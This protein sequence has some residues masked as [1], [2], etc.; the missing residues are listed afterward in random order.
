MDVSGSA[1]TLTS[2]DAEPLGLRSDLDAGSRNSF[3]ELE[4]RR[5]IHEKLGVLIVG[6]LQ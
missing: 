2:C 1:R 3:R 4:T 5:R 6:F